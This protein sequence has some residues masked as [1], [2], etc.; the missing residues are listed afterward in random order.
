ELGESSRFL[1]VMF[2]SPTMELGV[3]IS[4][5]NAVYL[6]NVP[7]TP[8][9]YVQRAGRAGRSGQ[10]ALVV[11]YCAARSPHDQYFFRD[12]RAMVH[13]V[14][15]A[16]MLDLANQELIQS[17]LQAIWLASSGQHL[18]SSISRVL[19]VSIPRRPVGAELMQALSAPQVAAEAQRRSERVLEQLQDHLTA[20]R[21][22]WYPGAAIMAQAAIRAAPAAFDVA[23]K[24]WRDLF[25]AA[26]RQKQMA[27]GTLG[28][29][30]ITDP[31]ERNEAKRRLRQAIDQ[32]ELLLHNGESRNSDF[33]T[34]RYL[35]T[36]GFL[37]GYNFPRLPLMAY[38]PGRAD[39]RGGSTFLQRPRFLALSEFGPR[40]L[41]YHEGRAYRVVRVRIAP[42]GHDA[43][44]DGSQLP[45]R[46]V[47]ICAV[48]GAA[49]FDQHSNACH[50]CGVALADAQTISAL[51]RIENV[52]TEPAERITA[53]DE[54]R[55]R[56]AF[57]L[58]TTFQWNMRNGVPD[59]RTV[60][61][62]DAEGDVLRLH[63]GPGATITRI[64]RGLRR[65][66][67][68]SVFGFWVNPRTGSWQKSPDE[69]GPEPSP[70]QVQ[71][72]R[73]VPYVEDQKNALLLQPQAA[74][75]ETT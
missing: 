56:Q 55:Q 60:G 50:A 30:A 39:G 23:F 8:A 62:A 74:L 33:Y 18:E 37:P 15:R 44:A 32:I 25:E 6:R 21:A 66:R 57:E 12:P 67:D 40:S 48:C 28:N 45:S 59:V 22:P 24:R 31:R 9:N 41:V 19:D 71:P 43:M 20:D 54:E 34:Y 36:Q 29:Y 2:C 72:Q 73:I 42:S 7:P 35:A 3:D 27:S 51:Y 14:V 75:S 1:P 53:N 38:V 47:R 52:D 13:G 63:Y 61:A 4:A 70:D 69:D 68:Q 65:R 17:H 11:T 46:S 58:Q 16:P 49:H 5:L 26:E 10:A 64:N